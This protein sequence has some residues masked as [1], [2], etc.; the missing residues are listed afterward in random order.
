M[1]RYARNGVA[2]GPGTVELF[3][4]SKLVISQLTDEY[5]CESE[6]LFPYWMECRELMEKFRYINFNWVPRSQNTEAND[7]AQMASGYKDI[8]TGE[9]QVR[10]LEQDDPTLRAVAALVVG[11]L[12]GAAAG[13]LLVAAPI[14]LW[15][16]SYSSSSSSSGAE[17]R[18]RIV[19]EESLSSSLPPPRRKCSRPRRTSRPRSSPPV[20]RRQG[21]WRSSWLVKD[22]SSS[23]RTKGSWVLV[24]PLRW[25]E[26]VVRRSEPHSASPREMKKIGGKIR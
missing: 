1:R 11:A 4:D 13:K 20:P 18:R 19:L 3:G 6:S 12:V 16:P 25:G 22:L 23:D 15:E 7:L 9:V 10:F 8:Q 17:R 21:S 26:D 24:V 5:K 2:F 14:A